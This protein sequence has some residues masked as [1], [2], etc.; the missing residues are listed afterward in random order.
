M[1]NRKKII[2]KDFNQL[3][4]LLR[5]GGYSPVEYSRL[6]AWFC[7]FMYCYAETLLWRD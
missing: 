1:S 6:A 2:L 3:T 7:W 4:V 5:K